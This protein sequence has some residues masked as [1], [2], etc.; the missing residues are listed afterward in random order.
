MVHMKKLLAVALILAM[1][2]PCAVAETPISA[3]K[4]LSIDL[5]LL[6]NDGIETI[7]TA[8]S[9]SEPFKTPGGYMWVPQDASLFGNKIMIIWAYIKDEK[10][11]PVAFFLTRRQYTSY[12]GFDDDIELFESV[13]ADTKVALGQTGYYLINGEKYDTADMTD[14]VKAKAFSTLLSDYLMLAYP[15]GDSYAVVL[16][17]TKSE[18]TIALFAANGLYDYQ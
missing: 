10:F 2:I 13:I 12:E 3:E 18:S 5:S 17:A 14:E 8:I 15:F 4:I 1:L 6:S 16:N 7:L 9:Q 11:N